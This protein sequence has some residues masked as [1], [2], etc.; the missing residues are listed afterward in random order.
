M[1]RV[2]LGV[3]CFALSGCSNKES[4]LSDLKQEV[5]TLSNRVSDAETRVGVLEKSNLVPVAAV[6]KEE[7]DRRAASE[8]PSTQS[9]R[10]GDAA[11]TIYNQRCLASLTEGNDPAVMQIPPEQREAMCSGMYDAEAGR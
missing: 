7:P 10:V 3:I 5:S 9:N 1:H 2:L 6:A 8:S 11:R 4:E